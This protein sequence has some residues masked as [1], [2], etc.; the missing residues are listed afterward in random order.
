[1]K[2]F[3]LLAFTVGMLGS[4]SGFSQTVNQVSMYPLN[5]SV[6][7]SV[8]MI[9][10]FSYSGNCSFG[11]AYHYVNLAADTL[12]VM[13]VYCGYGNPTPCAEVDTIPL[14][15]FAAGTYAVRVEFHQGSVCPI[16]GFD[17]TLAQFDTSLT[18]TL[19]T[20]I[21]SVNSKI[22]PVKIY[23]TPANHVL[24]VELVNPNPAIQYQLKN[25]SGQLIKSG[26]F[27]AA[28]NRIDL[29]ALQLKSGIYLLETHVTQG[30][31]VNEIVVE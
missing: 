11:M 28:V 8:F 13:P 27:A 19:A 9:V 17:A 4:F 15:I 20:T 10:D 31:F 26:T 2:K 22:S 14:G 30:I 18:I 3:F 23:P 12:F 29:A 1:M 24:M 16:S 21:Q 25:L 5:P 6:N 7:D